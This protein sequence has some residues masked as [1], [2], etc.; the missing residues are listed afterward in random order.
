MER[1][2]RVAREASNGFR[3]EGRECEYCAQ[4]PAGIV[5]TTIW[6]LGRNSFSMCDTKRGLNRDRVEH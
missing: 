3:V 5:C 1:D 2:A 4:T 6:R